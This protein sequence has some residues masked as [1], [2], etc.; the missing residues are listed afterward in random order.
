MIHRAILLVVAFAFSASAQM[1]TIT[2]S[3]ISI[4]GIPIASGTVLFTPV[5]TAGQPIAFV[6]G[7]GGLNSP[8]ALPCT[9]TAGAITG[10]CQI[11]D[12]AL[13]TPANLLYTIDVTNTA[14]NTTFR[15]PTVP[16]ITGTSWA[17]DQYAPSAVTT[18][19]QP[20]QVTYGT[21]AAPNPCASGFYY[22]TGVGLSVCVGGVPVGVG[23]SSVVGGTAVSGV[24]SGLVED[25]IGQEGQGSTFVNSGADFT[26]AMTTTNVTYATT[27]GFTGPVAQFNGTTSTATAASATGT[28]VDGSLPFSF[29][30]WVNPSSLSGFASSILMANTS[31]TTGI[32]LNL[33]GTASPSGALGLFLY[34]TLSANIGV[35]TTNAGVLTAGVTSLVCFTYNGTKLASGVAI[36]INGV[37][38]PTVTTSDTLAGGSIASS[39]PMRIGSGGDTAFL[40]AIGR[41]RFFNRLLATSEILAMFQA[42]PSAY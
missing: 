23:S 40:G 6:T 42:G 26:N 12:S 33:F 38:V 30:Q 2:A 11:P 37:A 16:N 21:T 39:T 20:L 5:N 15:L 10:T 8:A 14:T 34:S 17:L 25:W 1:T 24:P 28:N 13:T 4:G 35:H 18:N 3:H 27:T 32:D 36:Y 22:Q 29:C 19:S 41:T 9:I 7:G 31:S